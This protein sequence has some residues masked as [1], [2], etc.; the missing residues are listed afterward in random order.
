MSL[1]GIYI[2]IHIFHIVCTA[3]WGISHLWTI[4]FAQW[5]MQ[6][7]FNTDL[8]RQTNGW[9]REGKAKKTP[10]CDCISA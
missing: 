2:K 4:R 8:G 5:N 9:R 6:Q 7:S 3:Q 10:S 1:D